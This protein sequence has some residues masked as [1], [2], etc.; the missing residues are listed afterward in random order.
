[1]YLNVFKWYSQIAGTT[2]IIS[3]PHSFELLL[4]LTMPVV[5][6]DTIKHRYIYVQLCLVT[7]SKRESDF[8]FRPASS[9]F[10]AFVLIAI[11]KD[12]HIL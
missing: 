9:V 11:E 2:E 10:N 5:S 3:L 4:V 7:S 8:Q 12:T 6:I 1:M